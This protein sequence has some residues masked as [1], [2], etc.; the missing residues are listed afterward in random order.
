METNI[1]RTKKHEGSSLAKSNHT[2]MNHTPINRQFNKILKKV[3]H[4]HENV[5]Q[6][7]E[8]LKLCSFYFRTSETAEMN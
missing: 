6:F 7:P 8:H 4:C 1:F 3:S 5:S 2:E